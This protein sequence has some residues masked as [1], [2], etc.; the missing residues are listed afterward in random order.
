MAMLK[1]GKIV[2]KVHKKAQAEA[3]ANSVL[4]YYGFCKSVSYLAL[5]LK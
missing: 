3:C 1:A 2:G 4:F 5:T